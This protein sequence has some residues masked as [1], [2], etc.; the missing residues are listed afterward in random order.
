MIPPPAVRSSCED[1]H[2][3]A[4][5]RTREP[6]Q[7]FTTTPRSGSSLCLSCNTSAR[8][9]RLKDA[10]LL[11]ESSVRL[12]RCGETDGLHSRNVAHIAAP[13]R[14]LGAGFTRPQACLRRRLP[15]LGPF[16][17]MLCHH[18]ESAAEYGGTASLGRGPEGLAGV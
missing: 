17:V 6:Q 4:T 7:R 1:G 18:P 14:R 16:G 15:C 3:P 8:R 9:I 2:T 13:K 10:R 11:R 12:D 5:Q